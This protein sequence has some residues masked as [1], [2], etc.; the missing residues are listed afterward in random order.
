MTT[1]CKPT[2]T[3]IIFNLSG[4]TVCIDHQQKCSCDSDAKLCV[5][6]DYHF[7]AWLCTDAPV[8]MLRL[9]EPRGIDLASSPGLPRPKSQLWDL[10]L[11]LVKSTILLCST[12][13]FLCLSLLP[14][15]FVL[16]RA[17]PQCGYSAHTSGGGKLPN[18]AQSVL[19]HYVSLHH[20]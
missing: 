13:L 5:M 2:R 4:S 19:C 20:D 17:E 11:G 3:C 6:C 8:I 1:S 14:H 18:Q 9:P 16:K 10:G 15:S 12:H 7:L